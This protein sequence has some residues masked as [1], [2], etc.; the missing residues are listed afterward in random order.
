MTWNTGP[1]LPPVDQNPPWQEINKQV[2]GNIKLVLASVADYM[3]K[4]QTT[5]ASGE[6]PDAM[7]LS[8]PGGTPPNI[9]NLAEFLKARCADLTPY[10]SGDA[11]KDY[12]NLANIPTS[13]WRVP[14]Y[15]NAIYG[16]PNMIANRLNMG[17]YVHQEVMDQAGLTNPNNADD[18]K[19]ILQAL[20]NPS[21]G[22]WG[23]DAEPGSAF[24]TSGFYSAMF[25]APNNWRIDASGNMT[26]AFETDEFKQAVA[27]NRDLWAAGVYS[28][29]SITN[30]NV[31]ARTEFGA[32][33]AIWRWDGFNGTG[34]FGFWDQALALNPPSKLRNPGPFPAQD[35][36]KAQYFLGRGSGGITVLKQASPDRIKEVLRVL[37]FIAAPFGS[38]EHLLIHYGVKGTDYNLDDSGNPV[39]TD[40]GKTD[41]NFIW[42]YMVSPGRG[43][44]LPEGGGIPAGDAGRRKHHARSRRRRP[45]NRPVLTNGYQ[46]GPGRQSGL[47]RRCG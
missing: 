36:G 42:A 21:A 19:R 12:P 27:Y 3:T 13:A 1:P 14:I 37:N 4:V 6:L 24:I 43:P 31:Q 11:I 39:L 44:V 33:K 30:S 40:Q 17:L 29:N 38:Q 26:K 15:A 10:L 47:H 25:G 20:T 23:I 9:E 5:I 41:M 35:G 34:T 32:R 16:I 28:A 8:G 7:Y 18:W 45:D 46:P 22:Q 2:G